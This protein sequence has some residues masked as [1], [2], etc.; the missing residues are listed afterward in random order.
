M[1]TLTRTQL[2]NL[3]GSVLQDFYDRVALEVVQLAPYT[4]LQPVQMSP[5]VRNGIE[6]ALAYGLV[7]ERA[8]CQ[9]VM[10]MAAWVPHFDLLPPARRVLQD[11][12]VPEDDRMS[13][14]LEAEI[15][16]CWLQD[17]LHSNAMGWYLRIPGIETDF[18]KL[19]IASVEQFLRHS[20]NLASTTLVKDC[21]GLAVSRAP[22]LGW[23][24]QAGQFV[25]AASFAVFGGDLFE[26]PSYATWCAGV[27][28]LR[29]HPAIRLA[30]LRSRVALTSGCWI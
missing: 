18:P 14:L 21:V 6:R 4:A 16:D 9:F 20:R 22:G 1:L 11:V 29:K 26:N 15:E 24:D 30:M 28:D 7:S 27:A 23:N 19:L 5:L 3:Q 2:G 13:R 8:L 10:T 12:S 17:S 25:L